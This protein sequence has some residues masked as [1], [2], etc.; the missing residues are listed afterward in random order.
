VEIRHALTLNP[1]TPKVHHKRLAANRRKA[2][3]I[4]DVA[5]IMGADLDM[6]QLAEELKVPIAMVYHYT[7]QED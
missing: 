3:I 1:R 6:I 2:E 5:A 4:K 7:K